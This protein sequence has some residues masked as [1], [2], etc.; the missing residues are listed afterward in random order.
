[1]SLYEKM[2]QARLSESLP[3]DA[4]PEF[5]CLVKSF[6]DIILSSENTRVFWTED[7][8]GYSAPVDSLAVALTT[9]EY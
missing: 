7:L 2:T 6:F 1:M 4:C 3:L 8:S 9:I 5:P